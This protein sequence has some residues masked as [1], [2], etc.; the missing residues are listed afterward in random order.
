MM[1]GKGFYRGSSALVTGTAGTGKTSIAASFVKAA[2]LRGEK[3][4]YFAFEESSSQIIRNMTSVGIDLAECVK[5]G[6][7]TFHAGRPTQFGLEMHLAS[8]VN[9]IERVKPS[10]VVIDPISNFGAIGQIF[11]I[12]SMLSRLIDYLKSHHITALFTNL[13]GGEEYPRTRK[14]V[15]PL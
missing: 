4:L 3:A 1:G 9:L 8:M 14:W 10:V 6:L 5:S 13:T 11:E 7:L 2:C 12:E 15:S